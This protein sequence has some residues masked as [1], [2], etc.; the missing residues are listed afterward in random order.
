MKLIYLIYHL[1][2][3]VVTIALHFSAPPVLP[4]RRLCLPWVLLCH[5]LSCWSPAPD[6]CQWWEWKLISNWLP[7]S[8]HSSGSIA[9]LNLMQQIP[10]KHY[11]KWLNIENISCETED[12]TS[13]STFTNSTKCTT[14]KWMLVEKKKSNY[15]YLHTVWYLEILKNFTRTLFDLIDKSSKVAR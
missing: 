2:A 13:I 8:C 12:K 3:C 5:W 1:L 15:L 10:R 9:S 11:T 14:W 6:L 7:A 4:V